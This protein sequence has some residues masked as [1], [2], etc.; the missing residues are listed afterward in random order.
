VRESDRDD[1]LQAALLRLVAELRRG[2]T[3][4]GLPFRVVAHQVL[5]WAIADHHEAAAAAA[6]R[7]G[8]VPGTD[9][10]DPV[11]DLAEVD[12]RLTVD[13]VI[14]A[15]PEGDR[16]PM[17]LRYVEGCEYRRDRRRL[18]ARAMPSTS[19]SPAA[20]VT[21]EGGSTM[22]TDDALLGLVEE[23]AASAPAASARTRSTMS[24]VPATV[25]MRCASCSTGGSWRPRRPR[26]RPRWSR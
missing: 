19:R 12:V 18:G 23:F 7:D 26:R 4:G 15:L 22:A 2:K 13:A 17:R 10:A 14:A 3:Y 20:G 21:S 11:D 8:A 9:V 1:V 24:P 16:V 6:R 5:G 25:A